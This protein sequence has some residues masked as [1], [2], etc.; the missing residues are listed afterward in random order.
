MKKRAI[1]LL[2]AAHLFDDVNQGVI[3][4]LIPFFIS[5]RGF[6]IAAAAGLVF[7]SNV[8]SSVLQPLFGALA[9]RKSTPWLV[10]A[11]L[12]LAGAGVAAAGLAPTYFL[13]LACAG[14]TG[15]GVAAFHPEAAR[16]VYYQ[17]GAKRATAMSFFATGG[18]L[19]F[20]IGPAIATPIG[21]ALGLR[22]TPVM[23][24]P[25]LAMALVLVR[26]GALRHAV[27]NRPREEGAPRASDRW[28]AFAKLSGPVLCRA[29]V[30]YALNTFIPLYWI[31]EFSASKAAGG[32][33]LTLM[34]CS[35]VAGTLAG[36]WLAD[37]FGRRIV[38]LSSMILLFPLLLAFLAAR[39]PTLALALMVPIGLVLYSPFS[40]MTVLA[41]E[42]LPGR[43]GT[44]SGLTIGL[45]VTL[46][47]LAAPVLGRIADLRGVRAAVASVVFVPLLGA[48]L[49][50]TL[51]REGRDPAAGLPAD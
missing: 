45:A 43:V 11:G 15:I 10:P 9:D 16:Q 21:I 36:G 6:T 20:A 19:G 32:A 3:P 44:A 47:G 46:G 37:R 24:L 49:A 4:A 39:S 25:A 40:V 29:I 48:A 28:G 42:Y 7:G 26:A 23:V 50:L 1:A 34:L 35:G 14:V 38:V 18:N 27:A 51:P 41:Q 22:G 13:V 5:E 17:S 30:F 2:A 33:A 12:F 31:R 8:S